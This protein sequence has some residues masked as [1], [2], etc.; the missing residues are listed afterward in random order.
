MHIC[1]QH[2]HVEVKFLALNMP[3][4]HM[5][6][7]SNPDVFDSHPALCLWPGK[8][9][10]NGSKLWD[11]ALVWD[12]EEAPGFRLAQSQLVRALGEWTIRWKTFLSVSPLPY[13]YL[14]K[15]N[16]ELF[17]FFFKKRYTLKCQDTIGVASTYGKIGTALY[18]FKIFKPTSLS[19][20][21]KRKH[22]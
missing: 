10:E 11:P 14:S 20:T 5:G 12:Q 21:P 17:V 8:A 4:S 19:C 18:L 7:S 3:W 2:D 16:K 22:G 15:K 9:V 1:A 13:I 6:T